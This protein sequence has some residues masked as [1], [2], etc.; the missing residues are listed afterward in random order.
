MYQSFD[1]YGQYDKPDMTLCNPNGVQLYSLN[2][3][4]EIKITLKYNALSEISFIIDSKI[5]GISNPCYEF[6]KSKRIVRVENFGNFIILDLDEDTSTTTPFKSVTAYSVES[7]MISKKLSV[8]GGT[9]KFYGVVSPQDIGSGIEP[10][11]LIEKILSYMPNWSVGTIDSDL[12]NIYRT[13]DISDTN[14]YNFLMTDVETA[15]GCVFVF[16][17]FNRTI[18]AKTISNATKQT[19]I[20]ISKEALIEKASLKEISSEIAT[21]LSVFGGGGLD[22]RGVNPLGTNTIYDFSY[23]KNS[24]WMSQGLVDAI[25]AW[26]NLVVSQQ[27]VY[28][29]LLSILYDANA[30]L[31]RLKTQLTDLNSE[32]T[33]METIQKTRIEEGKWLPYPGNEFSPDNATLAQNMT[34][35]LLE[36]SSKETEVSNQQ[37]AIVDINTSISDVVNSV[38]FSNNFTNEQYLELQFFIYENTYQNKNIIVT[39]AMTNNDIQIQSQAL[40]DDALEV[41]AKSSQPRYEFSLNTINFFLL[42]EFQAFTSQL[43]MGCIVTINS[44]EDVLIESVLLEMELNISDPTDFTLTFSN[45]LRLDNGN[46]IF[47]DLFGENN[48]S[49]S[50]VDFNAMQWDN[51][52]NNYKDDV[53]T[54]ITSSLDASKNSVINASNQEI[55]IN[56]NGLRGKKFIPETNTY[57]PNQVWLTSSTLAFTRDNW[58]TASLAIGLV[59]INDESVYGIV[60]DAIVGKMIA[61]N[62]LSIS[63]TNNNFILDSSGAFLNNATFTLQDG[64]DLPSSKTKIFITPIGTNF[65]GQGVDPGIT[66]FGNSG[67][68]WSKRFWVDNAGNVNFSGNL[69]GASGTFSGSITATS[70]SIGGL[71]INSSGIQKDSNNYIRSN[72]DFKWGM[73]TMSGGSATFNGNIY[74]NNL[75][76]NGGNS[77]FSSSGIM[78]GS[79]L[80]G[81]TSTNMNLNWDGIN[82]Y[83]SS[84]GNFFIDANSSI[85]LRG[86][87]SNPGVVGVSNGRVDI[88]AANGVSISGALRVSNGSLSFFGDILPDGSTAYRGL[89]VL[90]IPVYTPSG[91]L[92]YLRFRKGVL[93]AYSTTP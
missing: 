31:L 76:D 33:T 2:M 41:L 21:A 48:K 1:A 89:S 45:R 38:S 78:T 12:W 44:K 11:S 69:S 50:S 60:A 82:V 84:T 65:S 59:T 57:S 64:V 18:S 87:S 47:S 29:E 61:G 79:R 39:D 71:T 6:V 49:S 16:D 58:Q 52:G 28:S 88:E 55:L 22:I 80:I 5:N 62:Q 66:I 19:D 74:A 85:A 56:T 51:W 9:Y 25:T 46:F 68:T 36:I 13:F 92:R 90:S 15:F 32:Y 83:K 77:V 7:E 24:D 91:G 37:Q 75:K 35:K 81:G 63:N 10:D 40:Y 72:G 3:A 42:K 70:G 34:N 4:R 54:F 43:E 8:F 27:P 73:L 23:Y 53:T 93:Y 67:G 20:F 30:N 26:E 17:T 86:G 14:I